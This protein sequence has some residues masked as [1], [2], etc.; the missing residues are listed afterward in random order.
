MTPFRARFA[1][2][3][4]LLTALAFAP[5]AGAG[6]SANDVDADHARAPGVT[7]YFGAISLSSDAKI[8]FARDYRTRRGAINAAKRLC[9]QR[10]HAPASCTS[11]GWMRDACGALSVRYRPNGSVHRYRFAWGTSP[12]LASREARR[13]F[14]GEIRIAI[15]TVR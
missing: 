5:T 4:A 12:A 3:A 7:R 10:S 9:R 13:G 11:V 8:G 15:C 2:T 14:G 1:T 6:A